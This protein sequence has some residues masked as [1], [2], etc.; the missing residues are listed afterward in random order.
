MRRVSSLPR[1]CLLPLIDC[2]ND[3]YLKMLTLSLYFFNLL[4][5]PFLDGGQLLDVLCDWWASRAV[6]ADSEA[7]MLSELEAASG[8]GEDAPPS[9]VTRRPVGQER[10]AWKPWWRRVVHVGVGALLA[11]CVLLS[12]VKSL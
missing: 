9:R 4:P 1:T 5:L 7:V 3:R 11:S 8:E 6:V 2:A 12:L 10:A